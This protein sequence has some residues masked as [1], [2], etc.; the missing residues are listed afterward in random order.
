MDGLDSEFLNHL[1][2]GSTLLSRGELDAAHAAL[3][4]AAEL[5]P[6][7]PQVLGLLGQVCYRQGR[8][9]EA[10][11]AYARLVAETPREVAPRVNLGLASLKAR[12]W[13]DAV[14]HL[15]LALDLAPDHAR[16]RNYLG[17]AQ[18]ELGEVEEARACFVRSGAELMVARCDALLHPDVPARE[19][20]AREEPAPPAPPA[21]AP[22]P[23][24]DGPPSDLASAF[25]Q[26]RPAPAPAPEAAPAPAPVPASAQPE[27]DF[28][29]SIED[30]GPE[31]PPVRTPQADCPPVA[32][33]AAERLLPVPAGEPFGLAPEAVAV[34]VHGEVL[35]RAEGLLAVLG[36]VALA[37]EV[38]RFR[39]K[40]TDHAFGEGAARMWRA[41]GDGALL[42]RTGE[43]AFTALELAGEAGYFRE[44]TVFAFEGQVIYENGRLQSRYEPAIHLVHLR[45]EGRFL[46]ASAAPP[47]GVEVTPAAPLRVPAAALVGWIGALT[48]R[49][50]PLGGEGTDSPLVIELTGEGR[51]LLAAAPAPAGGQA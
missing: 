9:D 26:A 16:A 36:E 24:G 19:E 44:E 32:R 28:D 12:A 41:R 6:D 25:Q 43:R 13:R 30:A 15:K 49:V 23:A 2:Q 1:Q 20:P 34:H 3:A 48:P 11:A 50:L 31:L 4:S 51:A 10:A 22:A 17:L 45:G 14:R 47:E 35:A 18:L 7:D 33:Y 8:F 46:L 37:P 21:P 38:K 5:R 29:L 27:G 42:F 40:A 39:G